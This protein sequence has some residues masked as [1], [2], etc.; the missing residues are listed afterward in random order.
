MELPGQRFKVTSEN[1][2]VFLRG[3]VK[4]LTASAP[5]GCRSL[6]PAAR[7]STCST[8][9]VPA[10][11]PQILL[12]VRFASVDRSKEKQLGIN[13]FSTGLGNTLG[14]ASHR[15]V[16]PSDR[17][18]G[19]GSSGATA[20]L[21]NELNLFAFF[22]GLNLGATIQALEQRG[23]VELLA[24]PNVMAVNGKEASFL[25]G[26]VV[27]YPVAQASSGGQ[28]A[29]TIM[30]KEYGIRL[31]FI[32]TL[33]PRGTIRLQVAP[34]V[35]AL[36]YAPRRR[37]Q[38]RNVP[39]LPAAKSRPRSNWVTVKASWLADCWTRQNRDLSRRSPS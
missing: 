24:E 5:R 13:V 36:D 22:P 19:H 38:R 7:S 23:I 16:L 2:M 9:N 17:H 32:P 3:T 4:D 25:A 26:G 35:S 10:A 33:T 30:F 29:I 39:P 27:P 1:N 21:S 31:N 18:G 12:K 14:G 34:E 37:N 8:S 6:P 20:T 28:S 11:D 15:T